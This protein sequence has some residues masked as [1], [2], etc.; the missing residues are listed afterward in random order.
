[1]AELLYKTDIDETR[2]RFTKWWQG[3]DI[4]R[5]ALYIAIGRRQMLEEIPELP[6]PPGWT[7]DYSVKDFDYRVN[8]VQHLIARNVWLAEGIPYTAADLGPGSLA[9]FL[10]CAMR[11]GDGTAWFEP[12][13]DDPDTARFEYDAN[14]PYWD[15]TLRLTK[16]LVEIGRGKFLM[17]FPD[18][19]EGLDTLAS[20]RGTGN[21]LTDM[22]D[23]PE[24]VKESL[25]NITDQYYKYHDILYDVIR[26]DMGGSCTWAWAPGHSAKMQCDFSA[27]IS[28]GMFKD[29]MVPLLIEMTEHFS[30]T[31]YHWDGPGAIP[32]HDHLLSVPRLSMIQWTAGSGHEHVYD[33]R[34][35]PLYHKTIEAGK[36]MMLAGGREGL[37]M[38]PAMKR[39]FG[40]KLK[41]F[42]LCFWDLEMTMEEVENILKM[43]E[44]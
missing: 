28:P 41:R 16:A 38:L 2:R 10:G 21:L 34:W 24:W 6:A 40:A 37:E 26:D 32:H 27:M 9:L 5:P 43:V 42:L 14:N 31:I 15:F 44:D 23:R 35:W 3:G 22:M 8:I 30:Y 1:V 36:S 17:G 29:F 19:V 33:P 25:R 18:L 7:T 13:I 20:M 11:D 12:C 4:G 39:E